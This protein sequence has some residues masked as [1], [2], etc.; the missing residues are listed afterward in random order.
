VNVV[1]CAIASIKD[2][3]NADVSQAGHC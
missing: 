3:T 2:V 1:E